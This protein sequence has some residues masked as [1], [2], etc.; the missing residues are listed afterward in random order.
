MGSMSD[1]K[2]ELMAH[3]KN[4]TAEY[5]AFAIT[6]FSG[7]TI[8]LALLG[9]SVSRFPASLARGGVV[10]LL[11]SA[12]ALLGYAVVS[13]W[14]LRASDRIQISLITGA[15]AGALIGAFA[16][17]NHSIEVFSGLRAPIPAILGVTMWGLMF[18]GFGVAS[19]A[20]YH[21]VKSIGPAIFSSVW[22]ALISSVAT[23]LFALCVGLVF[24]TRMQTVLSA[25]H[26]Q[27]GLSDAQAFVVRN[28]LDGS[29][30][31]L[32]LAPLVAAVV[33]AASAFVCSM[34]IALAQ[35]ALRALA[36]VDLCLLA[37]GVCSIRFASSLARSNRPPF[38][39]A[40]LLCLCLSLA[41][42]YPIALAIRRQLS[43]PRAGATP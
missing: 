24:M 18:F 3:H 9:W 21:E 7:T 28:M 31:H 13:A 26:V 20:T 25:A 30:A 2:E 14:A 33:G 8:T 10:S 11:G 12:I 36:L 38:I 43:S 15:K 27:S 40:G 39:M 37:A 19:S 17:I 16:V 5:S 4:E 29:A 6:L 41:T 34:I 42:A 23:V 32:L 1:E 35:R 22:S